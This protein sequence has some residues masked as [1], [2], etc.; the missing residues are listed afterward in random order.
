MHSPARIRVGMAKREAAEYVL[1]LFHAQW[2]IGLLPT[3]S[4]SQLASLPSFMSGRRLMV[5]EQ[6]QPRTECRQRRSMS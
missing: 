6:E 2:T 1:D 4:H 5:D 3:W